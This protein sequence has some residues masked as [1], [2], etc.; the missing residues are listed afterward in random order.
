MATLAAGASTTLTLQ[1]GQIV[2]FEAGGSGTVTDGMGNAQSVGAVQRTFG[3]WPFVEV[4]YVS[5]VQTLTYDF[6]VTPGFNPIIDDKGTQSSPISGVDW[7]SAVL[8][9]TVAFP[10]TDSGIRDALER[11]KQ[12]GK[13]GIVML[14]PV[15]YQITS[16]IEMVRNSIIEGQKC[17]LVFSGD[18][19]DAEFSSNGGTRLVV[20]PGVTAFKWNNVNKGSEEPNIAEESC[21]GA[22]I[23]GVTFIGGKKA[24]DTG[25]VNAMG[26]TWGRFEDLVA[27]D[28]TDDYAFDF[29]NFQHCNFDRIYTSSQLTSGSGIRFASQ[30]SSTLLPGNSS[31]GEIYTYCKNR[32]NRSITFEASGVA[33]S[34]LNQLKVWGRL[35]GNRYGAAT[36]EAISMVFTNGSAD[37]AVADNDDFA[38]LQIGMPIVFNTTAPTPF[39]TKV[40]YFVRA[41]GANTV[42]LAETTWASSS[43]SATASGTHTAH[44][45]GWP[46]LYVF[47][48]FSTSVPFKNGDLGQIDAEAFGNVAAVIL[49][50]TRNTVG[51]MSEM[52]SSFSGT[53]LVRRDD[54]S[55][56][57]HAGLSSFTE[58][59]SGQQGQCGTTAGSHPFVY[60][61]GSFTLDA[62]WHGRSV[63]Y[64]GTADITITVP[65]NLPKGFAMSITPTGATGVVTFAAASGGAI[66]SKSGLR[67]NGQYATARLENIAN[68]VFRLTGDLQV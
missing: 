13:P 66:F 32:L 55:I 42:Q 36:P 54:G 62:S 1:V 25:A 22:W 29:K 9:S 5:A 51:F 28:Q 41:R 45:S 6:G 30:L 14:A 20:S 21:Q 56:L 33:G 24:I 7:A 19:P 44:C 38:L 8:Q 26:V 46:S 15:D 47:K 18:I 59:Q 49:A 4:L 52:S 48:T 10:F 40:V 23:R 35:Q 60:S 58:D 37:I 65:L 11:V 2:T 43:I 27:F 12:S 34:T 3:P 63:R 64:T 31:I 50:G 67:T 16:D 17:A 53:G 39:E 61:G 57:S 68:K